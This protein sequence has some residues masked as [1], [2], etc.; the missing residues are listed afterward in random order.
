MWIA[1]LVVISFYVAVILQIVGA[2]EGTLN[3]IGK[4]V[5][6]D[7]NPIAGS[8]VSLNSG[9]Y[10]VTSRIDGSFTFYD[11]SSG[12]YSLDVYST[13]FHFPQLKLKVS[14]ENATVSVVEYKYPGAARI[15]A[16][17]PIIISAIAPIQYEIPKPPFSLLGMLMGNPMILMMIF[18]GGMA[19][20]MPK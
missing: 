3:V 18:M 16:P 7:G 9:E 8:P 1:G 13:A 5:L 19:F 20:I 17:Y 10:T 4:V 12:I 2:S 14:T 6:P 15:S 11:V